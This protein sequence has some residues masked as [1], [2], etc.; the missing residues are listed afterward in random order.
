MKEI[1]YTVQQKLITLICSIAMGCAYTSDVNDKLV[2]DTVA[3]RKLD[4]LRFPDQSQLNILL[5]ELTEVNIQQFK[6]IHHQL[7]QENSQSMNTLETYD[8]SSFI[9]AI[10]K[11][12]KL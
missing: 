6:E 3:P 1:K 5:R 10:M 9:N 11:T 2:Q 4:M 12:L 7:F 8:Y